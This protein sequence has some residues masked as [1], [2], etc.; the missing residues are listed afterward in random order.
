MRGEDPEAAMETSSEAQMP[1]PNMPVGQMEGAASS[2]APPLTE[3]AIITEERRQEMS[4]EVDNMIQSLLEGDK[5]SMLD[6]DES[7][8]DPLLP[9]NDLHH[10]IKIVHVNAVAHVDPIGLYTSG[11]VKAVVPAVYHTP[12]LVKWCAENYDPIT[13]TVKRR[14][15]HQTVLDISSEALQIML[16][17]PT[18]ATML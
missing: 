13:R 11:I 2:A 1:P 7:I 10:A 6:R 16:M 3:E 12:E 18:K 17:H 15:T 4:A 9:I 8:R 14:K 5:G